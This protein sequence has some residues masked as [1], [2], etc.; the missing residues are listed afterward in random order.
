M[1]VGFIMK[2]QLVGYNEYTF[3]NKETGEVED[4]LTLFFVRNPKITETGAVGKVAVP[5]T[6]YGK[7]ID[8][9]RKEVDL[10]VDSVYDCDI[11]SFKGRNKLNDISKI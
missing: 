7:Q 11:N 9:V 5:C 2:C 6:L 8:A 1:K 4:A 10:K 3:T